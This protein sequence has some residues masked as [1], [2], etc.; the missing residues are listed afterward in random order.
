MS[1]SVDVSRQLRGPLS[2]CEWHY[3][4]EG[5]A[6]LILVYK[7]ADPT[8]KYSVLRLCKVKGMGR[9]Q[10]RSISGRRRQL[11]CSQAR[12][13][14]VVQGSSIL[15]KF[16]FTREEELINTSVGTALRRL[17]G[18]VCKLG[19]LVRVNL[20]FLTAISAAA[21]PERLH[22]R[23]SCAD[24]DFRARY[25]IVLPNYNYINI[26]PNEKNTITRCGPVFSVE[27]KPKCGFLCS[28]NGDGTSRLRMQ[29]VSK[30]VTGETTRL[31]QYDPFDLFFG[32]GATN[33]DNSY[34]QTLARLSRARRAL[35][36]LILDPQNNFRLRRSDR[37]GE[38]FGCELLKHLFN[39]GHL[40]KIK[41]SPLGSVFS[42]SN[43]L[44]P[45]PT[46]VLALALGKGFCPKRTAGANVSIFYEILVSALLRSDILSTLLAAQRRD[47]VGS[48]GAHKIIEI[49]KKHKLF[50]DK[51]GNAH[52][53]DVIAAVDSS[54]LRLLRDFLVATAVKDCSVIL[55]FQR[56]HQEV[57]ESLRVASNVKTFYVS[58]PTSVCEAGCKSGLSA[59]LISFVC[60][61]SIVDL[62]VK[63][64]SKISFWQEREREIFSFY[65]AACFRICNSII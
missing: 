49:V 55:S 34:V 62:D 61:I 16:A 40:S 60:G 23:S 25:A 28:S 42:R 26:L 19:E 1:D 11:Y 7:G 59:D 2:A 33:D 41:L 6:H 17:H 18:N 48:F 54:A 31:S 14:S 21:A 39:H 15:K 22:S 44:F 52:L 36:A 8:F 47:V 65:V 24:I 57:P 64:M 20:R 46:D 58:L 5:A 35:V 3:L 63:T 13:K 45:D 32:T 9:S 50:N 38:A 43:S 53:E 37:P 51:A 27:I 10:S 29:Q 4:A 30:Y 12:Q 56:V